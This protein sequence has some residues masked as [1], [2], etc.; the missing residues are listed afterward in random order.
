MAS[1]GETVEIVVLNGGRTFHDRMSGMGL[2]PGA[3]L[4]VL[5]NGGGGRMVVARQG[6]RLFLGGGMAQKVLVTIVEGGSK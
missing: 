6:T 2:G 5:Q 1:E 4:E 3:R